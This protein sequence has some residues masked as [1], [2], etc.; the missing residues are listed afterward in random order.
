MDVSKVDFLSSLIL[1]VESN[2]PVPSKVTFASVE[3][4]LT[5][6]GPTGRKEMAWTE[7][8]AHTITPSPR[9]RAIRASFINVV[10]HT[11]KNVQS[12]ARDMDG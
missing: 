7:H 12:G 4:L 8:A 6:K 10:S 11:P 9:H 1:L 2:A 3:I 5:N